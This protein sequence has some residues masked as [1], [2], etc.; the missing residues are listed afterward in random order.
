MWKKKKN[1]PVRKSQRM[2]RANLV[3]RNEKKM[4]QV[5]KATVPQPENKD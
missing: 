5:L 2:P 1:H 3:D 4:E